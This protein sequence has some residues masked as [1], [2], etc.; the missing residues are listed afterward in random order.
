MYAS[1]FMGRHADEILDKKRNIT[2]WFVK[3]FPTYKDYSPIDAIVA[4]TRKKAEPTA[5]A[6]Q[7]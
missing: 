2:S 6:S 3:T 1:A 4:R 7:V 5:P